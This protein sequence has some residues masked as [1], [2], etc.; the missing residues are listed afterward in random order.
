MCCFC[1]TATEDLWDVWWTSS[2]GSV[3]VLMLLGCMMFML[4]CLDS[5]LRLRLL[6]R[7]FGED[8]VG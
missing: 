4:Q 5:M 8:L 1:S 3:A 6:E 7:L 2:L